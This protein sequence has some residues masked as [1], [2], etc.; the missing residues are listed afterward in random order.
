MGYDS[1]V[2]GFSAY[3]N[4]EQKLSN[5]SNSISLPQH[6]NNVVQNILV[7]TKK[8]NSWLEKTLIDYCTAEV[9]EK[10]PELFPERNDL[11]NMFSRYHIIH[12]KIVKNSN[13]FKRF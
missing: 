5:S 1:K 7:V 2:E 8:V 4:R 6:F 12:K 11:N 10:H 9:A 3:A 13:E